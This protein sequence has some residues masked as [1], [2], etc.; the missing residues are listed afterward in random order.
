MIA[1]KNSPKKGN[2]KVPRV[3]SNAYLQR[4]EE[5]TVVVN[6][7]S[8]GGLVAISIALTPSAMFTAARLAGLR[9]L[10]DEIRFDRV[11]MELIP[12]LGANTVSTTALYIERDPT[13]AVVGTIELAASQFESVN[14]P[15]NRPIALTWRPQQPQDRAFNLLNPGTVSLGT[16]YGVGGSATVTPSVPAYL[17]HIH[18][19]AT[20]RGRP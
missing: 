10:H 15:L 1:R 4:I 6:S 12:Q 18:V 8:G 5:E 3:L 9:A 14:G 7:T 20:V 16:F 19:W 11:T 13:A 17:I 2:R